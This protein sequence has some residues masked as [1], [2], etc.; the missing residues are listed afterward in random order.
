LPKNWA[1]IE[2]LFHQ[3]TEL[4]PADRASFLAT[5]CVDDETSRVEVETLLA[6]ADSRK[7][8]PGPFLP[9]ALNPG[10]PLGR[11]QILAPCGQGA[12]GTVYRAHDPS[13]GCTVA[14]KVFPPLLTPEQRRRQLKEVQAASVLNHPH[15][16]AVEETGSDADRDYLVMEYVDG[17]TLGEVIPEDGMPVEKALG[18]ARMIL[19][20][21]SAAHEAGIIHRDLK[22]SNVMLTR[23]GS[24]KVLD[25]GLAKMFDVH[26]GDPSTRTMSTSTGQIVGTACYLSPEQA[27]GEPVDVRTDIFSFGAL[28]YE[29]LT[30][31]RPFDRGSLGG[32]LAAI[33]RDSPPPVREL[34]SGTPGDVSR[35]VRRCLEKDRDQRY[36][37]AAELLDALLK[38]RARLN[39][40]LRRL[41]RQLRR[42]AI[43][44]PVA[45]ALV[46]M[47]A[48][49]TVAATRAIAVY[50]ARTVVEP[51]IAR[52]VEQH[53][54][55]SADELVRR[56]EKTVPGDQTV[57][58]FI[59]DYRIVTSIVTS[60]VGAEVAIKDYA[61]PDQP[62]RVLGHSPLKEVTIPLGYMRWRVSTPAYRTREFAETGIL[63]P[64][65]RFE[66]FP[67]GS[68]PAE[69][70]TVPAGVTYGSPGVQVAE[71]LLDRYE[72]TNRKY[73]E[74]VNAGG[75]R[76]RELWQQPFV[77]NDKTLTWDQAMATFLD[78]TGRP[79]PAGWQLGQFPEGQGD[80][81]VTGVS[82]F[83]AAAY[84]HF[85]GK[86]LPAYVEWLRAARTEWLYAD[87]LL[88]SNFS[89]KGL[90][91]VGSFRGL[92]R[93]GTYDL[94]GNCKEWLWNEWGSGQR[95]TMGGAW[96]EA[97]YAADTMDASAPWDR[98]PNIGFRCARSATPLANSVLDPVK[99]SSVRDYAVEKPVSDEQFAA[100]H[101]IYD[102]AKTPLN[103]KLEASDDTNP[104]WTKEK[105]SFDAAYAG[106]RVTAFLFVPRG[107]VPP[108][109]TVVYFASGIAYGEKSS[110]HLE[111]WFLDP[112]IRS[113]RAV[114]YP[115]LWGMYERKAKLKVSR[116]EGISLRAKREVLDLR[117]ALDY[118]ETRPEIDSG[119]LAYFGFSAGAV[120]APIAL[121]VE[122]RFKAAEIAVGGFEQVLLPAGA[123]PL[124]FAPR[125]LTPILM[126][127]GRYDVAFPVEK[128]SKPLFNLFG[129][130]PKDKRFVL[131]EAG[132]AMVGI[133]S[134]IRE[135]L[136]W[137]DRYL[138]PA[139]MPVV[140]H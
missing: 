24:I 96:D 68:Q 114:L 129:A 116:N 18:L 2:T 65:I 102:Y 107:A 28:L 3:A 42:P 38:C 53:H 60:P 49:L 130:A 119:K 74:F 50:K 109:Q 86:R 11:F 64:V 15:I 82:W 126:M 54:Y 21:L 140:Q 132:H 136:D 111:M 44:I 138:G 46:V 1:R 26:E 103:V 123:D 6:A 67:D 4:P 70:E 77:S 75:Y 69:M 117:R 115:V 80:L 52:L 27:R 30:G 113:G 23:A 90:A 124:N 127:N 55:N 62:W 14:I 112:L 61:T 99:I 36:S 33:L 101:A 120:Y 93:F 137:L 121:A 5:T 91:A 8:L 73:Q 76:R 39:T 25:F 31:E 51:E 13:A 134:S 66:I 22:P 104:Y 41:S 92:D 20:G 79:G 40:P 19:E 35:L 87:G 84:A 97:M 105:I 37:S 29:M 139:P 106:E 81:P 131:L 12:N 16:V 128:S 32:T 95:L 135:S 56:I 71:F 78:Q 88:V 125:A 85:A 43:A 98:R 9:T 59:R 63:N 47:A 122:P 45:A 34:R 89:G 83:E 72:V 7:E 108:F 17:P 100:I 48:A 133:P 58:D 57:R 10:Q 94:A 118:L 110:E